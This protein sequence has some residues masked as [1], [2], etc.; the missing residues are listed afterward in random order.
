MNKSYSTKIMKK[1]YAVTISD[2]LG[3]RHFYLKKSI[4]RNVISSAIFTLGIIA[5]SFSANYL[6]NNSID[7]L[8]ATQQ[9]LEHELVRFDSMNSDLNLVISR[10][11]SQIENISRELVGIESSS[12]VETGDLDV[13][14]EYRIR[15]IGQFYSAREEEY[16]VIGSRVEQIE[17]VIG[18]D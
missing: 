17:D 3:A 6:Q 11:K 12:G 9:Q 15:T 7:S 14:L 16:S 2:H 1:H 4:K 13:P 10:Y 18:I 5:A 8:T